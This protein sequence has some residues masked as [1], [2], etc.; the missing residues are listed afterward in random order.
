M[1]RDL[2]TRKRGAVTTHGWRAQGR[3]QCWQ[4]PG[5]IGSCRK[6][7]TLRGDWGDQNR[8]DVNNQEVLSLH[9]RNR[10]QS[11]LQRPHCLM[12]WAGDTRPE[13][14]SIQALGSHTMAPGS[15]ISTPPGHLSGCKYL[16]PF[17]TQIRN[18]GSG[19]QNIVL[20][21]P[22]SYSLRTPNLS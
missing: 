13:S 7:S 4:T 20:T 5:K 8:Q 2:K 18:C 6:V 19:A 11:N 9:A 17:Q 14:L 22:A 15:A 3:K 10:S 21:I 12:G 1:W 16:G